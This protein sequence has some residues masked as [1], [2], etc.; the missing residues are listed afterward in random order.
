MEE[1]ENEGRIPDEAYQKFGRDG[2]IVPMACGSR[3]PK[4][5]SSY[6]IVAGIKAEEWNGFHDL[7]MWDEIFRGA[8]SIS[9]AFVGLVSI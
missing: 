9:A 1:W 5:F 6:P 7:V 4:E 8:A 2:F 3:I